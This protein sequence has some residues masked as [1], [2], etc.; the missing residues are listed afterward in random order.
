VRLGLV[1]AESTKPAVLTLKTDL[2]YWPTT[3]LTLPPGADPTAAAGGWVRG[4]VGAVEGGVATGA[5]RARGARALLVGARPG[6]PA[7]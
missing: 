1:H 3:T 4:V 6:P 2:R 5:A 7:V